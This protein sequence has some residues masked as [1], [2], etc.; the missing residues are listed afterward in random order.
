[1][2][3]LLTTRIYNDVNRRKIVL[4]CDHIVSF[5]PLDEKSCYIELSNR[6]GIRVQETFETLVEILH[7]N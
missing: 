6:D 1:M 2:K 7:K 5:E 4:N 3:T